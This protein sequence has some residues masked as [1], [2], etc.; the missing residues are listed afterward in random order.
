MGVIGEGGQF[1]ELSLLYPERPTV[2][3]VICSQEA[4]LLVLL[5]SDFESLR[6]SQPDFQTALAQRVAEMR[7]VAKTR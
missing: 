6:A 5:R 4:E 7:Y 3:N 1:G 2:A